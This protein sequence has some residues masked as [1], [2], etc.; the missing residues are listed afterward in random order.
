MIALVRHEP[1]GD[2]GC[3]ELDG[4]TLIAV[5]VETRKFARCPCPRSEKEPTRG[6]NGCPTCHG[7]GAYVASKGQ[8]CGGKSS[9]CSGCGGRTI[10]Q[11]ANDKEPGPCTGCEPQ[12]QEQAT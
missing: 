1:C 8:G 9:L 12:R 6:Q 3:G 7:C 5:C 4:K 2:A 11:G 10:W